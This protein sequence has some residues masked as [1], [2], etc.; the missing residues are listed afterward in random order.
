[1]YDR[2]VKAKVRR[3]E[4]AT[5]YYYRF[6]HTREDGRYVSPVGRTRTAPAADSRRQAALRRRSRAR[7]STAATTTATPTWL[8]ME[9]DFI[10]H[11][12]DYI[13]ETTGD[14]KL[15]G[16]L[17]QV[18]RVHRQ[19]RRDRLQRGHRTSEYYA[20]SERSATTAS[21]TARTAPTPPL[22]KV[23]ENLPDDLHVGRPRVLGRLP[24]G[25]R[26][27]LRRPQVDEKDTDRR[28]AANQAWF[29]YMPIDF[30]DEDFEYH[31][32]QPFPG[33]IQIYRDFTFGKHLRLVMTDLRS[34]RTDHLIPEDGVPR[35][36]RA[37]PRPS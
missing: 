10:I 4:P 35:R 23:H 18:G 3:L 26:R 32:N 9:L 20:A 28:R 19:G 36:R 17:G 37:R 14:P 30:A 12:G 16:D 11:L 27:L 8:T 1:M 24:P 13:Y 34:Y 25:R 5:T 29:E 33:D 31:P 7:T 6:I 15:P 21:C 22:R 2:C